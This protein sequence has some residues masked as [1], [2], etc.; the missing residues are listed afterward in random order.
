M[1]AV[2]INA[3]GLKRRDFSPEQI[4]T[5]KRAYKTLYRSGLTFAEAKKQ[6]AAEAIAA[7]E[8]KILADFLEAS[9]RGI[10]R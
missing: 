8:L 10:V 2:G 4:T 9:A 3:E 5:I 6:L 7:P 1:S